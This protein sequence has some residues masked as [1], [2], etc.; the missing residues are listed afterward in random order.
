MSAVRST[1]SL[2]R[3][4][5][6]IVAAVILAIGYFWL[7]QPNV[8]EY[9]RV[10][11]DAQTLDLQ[12]RTLRDTLARGRGTASPNER[13]G[14][15]LFEQ[16]V[17]TDDRVPEV[18]ERLTRTVMASDPGRIRGFRIA[19]GDPIDPA[20]GSGTDQPDPRFRLFPY[21][22]TA[23]PVTV[24]FDAGYEAIQRVVWRLQPLPT[25]VE[26]RAMELTRG[27]PLMHATM[28]VYVYRRG[29]AVPMDLPGAETTAGSQAPRVAVLTMPERW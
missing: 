15:D 19:T 27:L 5:P 8:A 26:I 18:V 16:T 17:P 4:L 14:L 2:T 11:T 10:R 12:V 13:I 7:V 6:V 29:A 1:S 22:V 3:V 9:F 23:T 21:A 20:T 28:T 24:T 25:V